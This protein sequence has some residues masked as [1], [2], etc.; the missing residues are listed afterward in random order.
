[1]NLIDIFHVM[2]AYGSFQA[3]N[4]VSFS[5]KKGEVFSLLGPNGAG[6][7][8]LIEILEGVRKKDSGDV[9][10]L[11]CDPWQNTDSLHRRVGVIP[12]HFTF[13]DKSTPREAMKYYAKIFGARVDT[14]R[15]LKE[16]L[17]EDSANVLFENLSGGQKQKMGL[18]LSLVNSPDILFLDEPTTGL[19]PN[20]R[21]AVWDVIR[22]FKTSGKTIILTTHYLEE[23]EH[24][25]DRVA[26]MDH[27][28]IIAIGTSDEIIASFGSGERLDVHGGE[29]LAKYLKEKTKLKITYDRTGFISISLDQKHDAYIALAAIE[30]SG[31]PWS[32]FQIKKDSLED[33]F[34]KLVGGFLE[35][36]G[37]V[38]K[39]K[40]EDD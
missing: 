38:K 25:S 39:V 13:V 30:E 28:R 37:E 23:A 11:G 2:K 16:V 12:Q 20:A 6:K 33:V 26:I 21:R 15:I 5:V 10:V 7:T 4:D 22:K 18:A 3:V 34:V 40:E 29:D 17:L 19:D 31:L 9:K 27:G 32:N 35:E 36:H 1:M 8:T 24:L 14:D